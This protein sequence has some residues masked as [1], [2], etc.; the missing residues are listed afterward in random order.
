LVRF[1]KADA[2][3][4]L[5][6]TAEIAESLGDVA[7]HAAHLGEIALERA[8]AERLADVHRA[9]GDRR[10]ERIALARALRAMRSLERNLPTELKPTFLAHPRNAALLE[11]AGAPARKT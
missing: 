4:E 10:R 1:L 2:E 11:V 3:A 8:A 5:E 6:P 9:L 7:D